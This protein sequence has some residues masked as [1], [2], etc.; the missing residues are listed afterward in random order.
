MSILRQGL[1]TVS[2]VTIIYTPIAHIPLD[3]GLAF[4]FGTQRN[5]YSID[6]RLG[7]ASGVTLILGF[8]LGVKQ[9]FAFFRYQHVGFPN[10]KFW[11]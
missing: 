4:A 3:T 10:A 1:M 5:L 8:A 11:D 2:H 6:L 9:I 7:F